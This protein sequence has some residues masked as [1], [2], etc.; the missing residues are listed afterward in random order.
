[1][2]NDAREPKKQG[3]TGFIFV[4]CIVIG[5]GFGLAFDLMPGALI[6]GFGI[7]FIGMGI[8]RYITGL[9]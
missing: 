5:L 7:G 8:A 1:M 9:W 4:G 2:A 3:I 6:I